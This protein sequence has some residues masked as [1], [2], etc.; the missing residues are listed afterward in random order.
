MIGWC[1]ANRQPRIA[2]D[3]GEEA[4]RFSRVVKRYDERVLLVGGYLD[5][6]KKSL[7]A[8]HGGARLRSV[9]SDGYWI[10]DLGIT[11]R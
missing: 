11:I 4:I 10:G 8:K 5:L 7:G 1:I 2:M 6:A 9:Y 3:V